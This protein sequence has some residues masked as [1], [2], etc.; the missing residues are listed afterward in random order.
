MGVQLLEQDIVRWDGP[1]LKVRQYTTEPSELSAQFALSIN[2]KQCKRIK[3]EAD[4]NDPG[5]CLRKYGWYE[6]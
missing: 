1:L 6:L 3:F 2:R 4:G 5:S